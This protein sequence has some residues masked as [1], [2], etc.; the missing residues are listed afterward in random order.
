MYRANVGIAVA[1]TALLA[2]ALPVAAAPVADPAIDRCMGLGDKAL[3]T[4]QQAEGYALDRVNR[5]TGDAERFTALFNAYQTAPDVTR[6]R[7][8]L[9]TM[10]EVFPQVRE[11]ILLDSTLEGVLPLLDLKKGGGE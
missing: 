11:K 3:Q 7:I 4:I 1:V 9:E 10:G 8:Y 6:T 5:A 2:I